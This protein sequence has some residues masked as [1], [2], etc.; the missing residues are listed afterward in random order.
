MK[1][2]ELSVWV[3]GCHIKEIKSFDEGL[4]TMMA[5]F[6]VFNLKF[7]KQL[8]NTLA[9]VSKFV[10]GLDVHVSCPVIRVFNYLQK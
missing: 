2:N 4:A 9:F 7:P 3:D 10:L 1:E 5:C 6:W 8:K